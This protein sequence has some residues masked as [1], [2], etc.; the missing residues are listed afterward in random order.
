MTKPGFEEWVRAVALAWTRTLGL[1]LPPYPLDDP[2]ELRGEL[3]EVC[4]LWRDVARAAKA[5]LLIP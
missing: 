2:A 3:A 1:V 5:Y 4:D